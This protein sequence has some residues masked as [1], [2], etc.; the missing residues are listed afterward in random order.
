MYVLLLQLYST[1]SFAEQRVRNVSAVEV[2]SITSIMVLGMLCHVLVSTVT[3]LM[4]FVIIRS[5]LVTL[6]L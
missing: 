1:V 5:T 4:V 3:R 2:T 6:A